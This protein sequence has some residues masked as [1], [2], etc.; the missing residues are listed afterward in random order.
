MDKDPKVPKFT[1]VSV[2]VL[3]YSTA[4]YTCTLKKKETKKNVYFEVLNFK[5]YRGLRSFI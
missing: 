5:I 3:L 4:V 2:G 1:A